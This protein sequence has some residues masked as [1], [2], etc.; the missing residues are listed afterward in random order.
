MNKSITKF[1]WISNLVEISL[2]GQPPA[3]LTMKYAIFCHRYFII[4]IN[5]MDVCLSII[6]QSADAILSCHFNNASLH[7]IYNELYAF[8]SRA[9]AIS[10]LS[11]LTKLP[12]I[13]QQLLQ[14]GLQTRKCHSLGPSTINLFR[15]KAVWLTCLKSLNIRQKSF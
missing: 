2:V 1:L 14:R 8:S 5:I 7:A 12:Q 4:P 11:S 13:V 9:F 6:V 10:I 15:I 3:Q